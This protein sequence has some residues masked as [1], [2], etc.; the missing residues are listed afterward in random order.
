MARLRLAWS[1]PEDVCKHNRYFS[2]RWNLWF[3]LILHWRIFNNHGYLLNRLLGTILVVGNC[4]SYDLSELNTRLLRLLIFRLS[5]RNLNLG[6]LYLL[7]LSLR[8][9]DRNLVLR[10][11]IL[12]FNEVTVAEFAVNLIG[13]YW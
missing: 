3:N 8:L 9:A 5:W 10:G 13:R 1:L 2:D 7:W 4:V 6:L 12:L 11:S